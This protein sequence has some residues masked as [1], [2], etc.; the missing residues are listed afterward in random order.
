MNLE[1]NYNTT[2]YKC[3]KTLRNSVMHKSINNNKKCR[4]AAI[5]FV[6]AFAED[7][8]DSEPL[9]ERREDHVGTLIHQLLIDR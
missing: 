5:Y 8:S 2:H 3:R 1:S 4:N 9:D 7:D 6:P